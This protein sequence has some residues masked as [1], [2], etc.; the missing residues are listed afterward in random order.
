MEYK[1]N[2]LDRDSEQMHSTR[3]LFSVYNIGKLVSDIFHK[4]LVLRFYKGI[5]H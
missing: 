1:S 5:I 2:W 4:Y 3:L